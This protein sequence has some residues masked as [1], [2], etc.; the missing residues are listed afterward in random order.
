MWRTL[1]NWFVSKHDNYTIIFQ[2]RWLWCLHKI[3]WLWKHQKLCSHSAVKLHEAILMMVDYVRGM[4]VK[5]SC[6]YG[7]YGSLSICSF[8]RKR[9]VGGR[10]EKGGGFTVEMSHTH[11]HT[12]A[13]LHTCTH[14]DRGRERMKDQH[15]HSIRSM[16][17]QLCFSVW[18][19]FVN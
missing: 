5:Q 1:M 4:T 15:K 6:K 18:C 12:H 19:T 8:F 10:E 11:T 16:R 7:K 9:K 14:T 2:F 3:I 13:C 17:S